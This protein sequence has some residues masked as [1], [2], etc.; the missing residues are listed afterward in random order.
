[1]LYVI[2]CAN[3]PELTYRGGQEP[4]VHLE[5]DL[6]EVVAWADASG[7]K[8]AFTLSNAGAYY[9]QF[10]SS[11]DQLDEVNWPA[12]AATDFR[13]ADVK[14]GKQAEFLVHQQFAWRLVRRIGVS[15]PAVAQQVATALRGA[16]YRPVV[17][18]RKDWYF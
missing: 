16:D 8:W 13:G 5:A 4:I 3:H 18:I 7:R 6:H 2:H 14:E 10:R 12:V 15:A 9:T 11:V 1:M 17:E